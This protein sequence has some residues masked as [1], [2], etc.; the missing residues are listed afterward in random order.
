MSD[1][2]EKN[3]KEQSHNDAS[4][5]DNAVTKTAAAAEQGHQPLLEAADK[6]TG[7]SF[8]PDTKQAPVK[9]VYRTLPPAL[10]ISQSR[11]RLE[12][13]NPREICPSSLQFLLFS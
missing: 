2:D 6:K 12:S 7:V 8:T 4:Y 13:S 9:I 11:T 1:E 10:I 3:E 5:G